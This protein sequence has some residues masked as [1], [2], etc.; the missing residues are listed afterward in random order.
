MSART[1]LDASKLPSHAFGS[2]NLMWWGSVG[3]VVI[4]GAM[5]AMLI[6]TTLY[7]RGATASW[8]P[9]GFAPPSLLWG[10]LNTGVLLVSLWPNNRLRKAA[11]ALDEKATRRWMWIDDSFAV[12]FLAVRAVELTALGVRWDAN[13]YGS[14]VWAVMGFH[15]L[16]L[17]TDAI[18]TF[19]ITWFF[20][21]D[22]SP[23]RYIEVSED[24]LYWNFVVLSWLPLYAVVYWLPRWT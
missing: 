17:L 2:R 4:E 7:L 13:A 1:W 10:T 9:P 21:L 16:H 22:P 15:T 18:E 14:A 23:K 8:P 20:H 12:A 11:E 5:F 6:A 3:F 19:V 24:C